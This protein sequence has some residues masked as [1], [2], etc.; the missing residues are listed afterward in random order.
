M[1]R[2]W[3][4]GGE[5]EKGGAPAFGIKQWARNL[6]LVAVSFPDQEV[7]VSVCLGAR[8]R[9]NWLLALSA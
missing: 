7:C 3:Q 1:A 6:R 2:L 5:E 4:G 9:A 8:A